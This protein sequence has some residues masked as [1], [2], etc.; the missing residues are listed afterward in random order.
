MTFLQFT[1]QDNNL[2]TLNMSCIIGIEDHIDYRGNRTT[3]IYTD[4]KDFSSFCVKELYED[5]IELIMD[6]DSNKISKITNKPI[7]KDISNEDLVRNMFKAGYLRCV[8]EILND[9]NSD[10]DLIVDRETVKDYL[11]NLYDNKRML[12][13][14]FISPEEL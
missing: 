3:I 7:S 10:L 6:D 4:N 5:I 8:S 14:D 13:K 2:I 11:L 9:L 1:L 12:L